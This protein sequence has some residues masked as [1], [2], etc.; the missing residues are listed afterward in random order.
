MKRVAFAVTGTVLGLVGLLSFK[1]KS[2]VAA[3]GALPSSAASQAP[4]ATSSSGGGPAHRKSHTKSP[5]SARSSSSARPSSSAASTKEYTGQAVETPYGVVQVAVT[6]T[7][8]HIDSVRLV[9][10]T[11]FDAQ[12]QQINSYAAPILVQETT[13]AQSAR[14][15]TVSGATYT[16]DGYLQSLQSALDQAGI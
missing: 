8:K 9:Q 15:D 10:L 3:T 7:G 16:S 2:P 4:A 6:T 5:R 11:A 14:I 1:T 12:S 13:A